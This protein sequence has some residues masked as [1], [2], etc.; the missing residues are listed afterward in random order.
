MSKIIK[1]IKWLFFDKVF[2]LILQFFIGVKIA[3]YYGSESFGMYNY[4]MSIVSFSAILFELLNDRVIKKFFDESEYTNIIY[5]VNIFRNL[6]AFLVLGAVIVLGII[7]K[8][9]HLFYYTLIFLCIDNILVISTQGIETYF[10]YKL[11]SKRIVILNNIIKLLSYILQYVYVILGYSIIIIP[12]IRCF[13]SLIRMIALKCMYKF[14]YLK[15]KPTLKINVQLI[16]NIIIESLYLWLSFIGFLIYTQTDKIMLGL[17]LGN[18]EVG[19]YSIAV[20]LMQVLA[21]L[22]TP[23]QVSIFPKMLELYKK[24]YKEYYN[25]YFKL[26]TVVTQLY[27]FLSILSIIVVNFLFLKIFSYQYILA[28]PTYIILTISV[29]FKANGAL[30]STHV[31]IKNITKKI[32]YK[33]FIGI[34]INV[35]LNYIFIKKY[36]V[37]G[38][39]LSTSITHFITLFVLDFFI[40]EYREQAWIQLKSL[41][42]IYLKTILKEYKNK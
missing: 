34:I 15:V 14:I 32:F 40:K 38:A 16:K 6:M 7:L 18:E 29:F 9:P 21:I 2:I 37:I 5:N 8:I 35:I 3:N 26:N 39:A 24:N 33:T 17:M 41:N 4:A 19:I 12:I 36:R 1:N 30:Q 27:L 11:N 13:G 22:I 10:D 20:N 31:T 28:I 42:P 23:I 25:F